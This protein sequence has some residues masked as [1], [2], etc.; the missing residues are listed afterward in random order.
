MTCSRF[1]GGGVPGSSSFQ[2]SGSMVVTLKETDAP[3][4]LVASRRT[5]M[6]RWTKVP[7]VTSCRGVRRSVRASMQ[8]RVRRLLPSMG[9]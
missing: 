9:W 3:A 4:R 5:S 1:Q 8:P 6:S 7:L 2:R